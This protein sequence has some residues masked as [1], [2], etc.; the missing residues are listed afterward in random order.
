[1]VVLYQ[2][3]KAGRLL[4]ISAISLVLLLAC[5]PFA[6]GQVTVGDNLKMTLSGN[7]GTSYEGSFGNNIG[8]SHGL[9]FGV[10][11][12]FDGYYFNPKF[13]SFQVRPYYDRIQ[14]NSESQTIT[15]G[16]GVESSLSLF[17]GSHFPGSISYGRDFSSNSEFRIA[18]VPSVLGDSSGSSV[19]IAWS[20]LFEG[21][22]SLY[23]NYLITDSTSTLLGTTMQSKSSSRSFSLNSNYELGGFSLHGNLNHYNTEF[24]TPSFLTVIPIS[25]AS[26]STIYG[27]TATRRLPLSGSLGMGWSRTTSESGGNGA[28]SNSYTASAGFSPWQ[29]LSVTGSWH[30]TTNVIAALAQSLGGDNILPFFISDSKSTAM[31]MNTLGTLRVGRGF[32]VSGHLSH[33]IQ[34]FQGRDF[35]DTQY[36]GSVNFRKANRFLGFLY[37]SVGV[38]DTATQEGNGGLGLVTNLG[39]THKFGRWET[40]ADVSYSQNTQTLLSIVTTSNYNYGGSLRRKINS[41]T[42]WN[43][44]FRESRSGWTAQN[45]NNNTSESF[46]TSLSWKKYSFSGN[47]SQSNGAALLGVNGTLTSTPLGSLISNDFLIFDARSFGVNAS[48]RLFRRVTVSGGYTNVSSSTTQRTLGSFNNGDRYN[49]RLELRLRRL[50]IVGGFD[51]AIQEASAVPGGPR[52]VNSYYLSL[53]RWFDVF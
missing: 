16:S 44:S 35:E 25:N 26:S 7:L 13:L 14:S 2:G 42:S 11:G 37:F 17:G 22:P 3:T 33:R 30:Y 50:R 52:V 12:A 28:A 53:S 38:V 34:H 21:L 39:V 10:N 36:G 18:G 45:G 29:R 1:V 51:R 47:Y 40:A 24:L 31:Y 19:D 5:V 48:T 20:A 9:G 6:S 46:A 15:R 49:A 41:D 23:A 32:A 4:A 8:S 27:V 43:A